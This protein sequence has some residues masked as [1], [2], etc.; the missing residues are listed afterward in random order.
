MF[1]L[2]YPGMYMREIE[3]VSM[4]IPCVTGPYTGVFCTLTLL[5]NTIRTT[6]S[7][8]QHGYAR[9]R[10]GADPRFRD[11]VGAIQSIT[12]S[13]GQSDS[14]LFELSLRDERYL[15]FEGAGAVSSWRIQLAKQFQPFD[16]DT[17]A[18]V[19]LH[20][21]YT[22]REGGEALRSQAA[23]ELQQAVNETALAE[24]R[25]GLYRWFSLKHEFPNQ[26]YRF[27]T[28]SDAD[29]GDHVQAFPMTS[30]RFPYMFQ[31]K[32][33]RIA[34]VQVVALPKEA[35]LEPFDVYLMASGVVPNESNDRLSLEQDPALPGAIA[36]VKS[37]QGQEKDPGEDWRL[38]LRADDLE[39][40]TEKLDDIGL[41]L[42]YRVEN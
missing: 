18:D 19:I 11:N 16:Y 30:D 27:L 8:S 7:L 36:Q 17:I 37:Y 32:R 24:N 2:D 35:D 22:A 29:T 39:S 1:D 10:D 3:N 13:H 41:I 20:L 25:R 21:R 33:L 5:R 23:T 4:T 14:G 31:G 38:R 40:P 26:W 6:P 34:G 28:D 15:P 9:T 42:Q 12:T